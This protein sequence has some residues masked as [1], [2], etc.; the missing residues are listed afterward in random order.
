MSEE[1]KIK[2]SI[3]ISEIPAG[4]TLEIRYEGKTIAKRTGTKELEK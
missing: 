3:F 4:G 2:K 1:E